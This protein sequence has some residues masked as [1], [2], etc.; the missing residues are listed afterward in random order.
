ME[1]AYISIESPTPGPAPTIY[2]W[3]A[4]P[5][6]GPSQGPTPTPA[7]SQGPIP[8]P[9]PRQGPT[10]N[11]RYNRLSDQDKVTILQIADDLKELVADRSKN[12]QYKGVADSYTTIFN[13]INNLLSISTTK[14]VISIAIK[15]RRRIIDLP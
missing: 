2:S 4:I 9:V 14:R 10:D 15:F 8:T 7:P 6:P 5:T 1:Q 12:A 13:L 11:R 3:S